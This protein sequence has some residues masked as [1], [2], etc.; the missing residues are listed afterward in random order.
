MKLVEKHVFIAASPSR[1]YELLTDARLLVEW[2]APYARLDARPGGELTWTH[3]NGDRVIGEYVELVPSRR[4]V[5]TYGWDREDIRIPP[6]STTVEIDLRPS[7]DGTELHLV[8]RG[9][10][11]PMAD[12]H[13]GGW[14]NY[15][16]RLAAVAE[17]R[18]PGEDPLAGERVPA[19]RDLGLE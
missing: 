18:D 13:S 12:A 2:M 6:G 1:V 11:G 8:H 3:V 17:G 4:I 16:A 10:A 15:L 7:N 5:F 9:L 19:A 14:T